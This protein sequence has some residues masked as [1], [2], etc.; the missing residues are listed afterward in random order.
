MPNDSMT[1]SPRKTEDHEPVARRRAQAGF[2]LGPLGILDYDGPETIRAR[3]YA[4]G[5]HVLLEEIGVKTGATPM[6]VVWT[7]NKARL[8][9]YRRADG[10]GG[11]KRRAVPILLIY[12]FVLKP[13][14]LDLVPG[15]SLVECLVEEGFDVYLLDFGISG[16]TDAGLSIGDL[17]LDYM[18]GVVEKVL[19]TSGAAEISLLGQSQGGTLCAMYASLFPDGPLK[20][21]V[22]LSAPTEFAPLNPGPF[23][24]W[25]YAS[26][27]SG[28]FFNPAIVPQFLGNLPT[29]FA[30]QV[31]SSAASL[32]ATT[33][34]MVARPFGRGL[35]VYD[36][37]LR[38]VRELAERDVSMRSW[39]AVSK[40]VDDAAPFPGETFR[41][42]VGDFYQ[43]DKLVKGRVKLRGH[44]V[45][46][47]NI[48]CSVLNVSGKWDYVVPPSQ[49][50]ATTALAY[51]PDQEY[52]S[53]DAGHVGML[54]GP[55]AVGSLW[56]R[57]RNWLE[58]RSGQ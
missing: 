18:H 1:L 37:A 46:L 51:G 41:K 15:N 39:L 3:K 47:S 34:S 25:T 50:K 53:L 38:E 12:G 6:E 57:L 35:S 28:A 27:N 26:R 14:I 58:P 23:G 29:D 2:S 9:R 52:I 8:Y 4:T 11:G 54:V 42:W 33:V 13:Y 32:Q 22:L 49:T 16:P 40:W 31:I 24:M 10:D 56:P 43:R 36:P 55:A 19:A 20:N 44:R 48:R 21:L 30:S 45:N 5:T 7:K 17:I